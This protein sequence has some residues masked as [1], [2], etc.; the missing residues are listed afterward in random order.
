MLAHRVISLSSRY[1]T[2]RVH[3]GGLDNYGLTRK[4]SSYCYA[5]PKFWRPQSRKIRVWYYF[6]LR[7]QAGGEPTVPWSKP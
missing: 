6:F 5:P 4:L 7:R 2:W 3:F 1:G